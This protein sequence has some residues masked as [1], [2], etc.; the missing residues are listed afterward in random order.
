M[1]QQQQPV[2]NP[3]MNNQFLLMNQGLNG[4][5]INQFHHSS[6]Q[7]VDPAPVSFKLPAFGLAVDSSQSPP[8]SQNS[9]HTGT[10]NSEAI[11]L[12]NFNLSD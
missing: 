12:S 10:S 1:Y 9:V 2:I 4:F 11:K 5:N 6:A 8:L 7:V 3:Y